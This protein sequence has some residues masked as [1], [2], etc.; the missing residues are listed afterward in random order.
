MVLSSFSSQVG[1]RICT[2]L[3]FSLLFFRPSSIYLYFHDKDLLFSYLPFTFLNVRNGTR[4]FLIVS[5]KS[6]HT[7]RNLKIKTLFLPFLKTELI[8]VIFSFSY[9]STVYFGQIHFWS[10][11]LFNTVKN[12]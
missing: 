2:S 3:R 6:I 7:T 12:L 11:K 8:P 5:H 9:L 4:D 10:R 1:S